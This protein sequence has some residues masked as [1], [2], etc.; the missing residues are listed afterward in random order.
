GPN[1]GVLAHLLKLYQ[2]DEA[3]K[4]GKTRRRSGKFSASAQTSPISSGYNT[5]T[6]GVSSP[7]LYLQKKRET[8]SS[9][10]KERERKRAEIK[11]HITD[12]IQKKGLV[13]NLCMALMSYGGPA[14]RLEGMFFFSFLFFS[15]RG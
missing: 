10:R 6:K 7:S 11:M 8:R 13:V 14:H 1:K 5:P 3:S 12:I 15:L 4:A 9:N 2:N